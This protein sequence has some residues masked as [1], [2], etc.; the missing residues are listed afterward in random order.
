MPDE[1]TV[2][3]PENVYHWAGPP[4]L[5]LL[6]YQVRNP[7]GGTYPTHA[8]RA[9]NG[10]TGVVIIAL[11][12]TRL[13]VVDQ[14]RPTVGSVLTELPRG[15]G[16]ESSRDAAGWIRDAERELYEETGLRSVDSRLLGTYAPDSSLLPD[17]VAVVR[18]RV[19]NIAADQTDGEVL[20]SRWIERS[21][22]PELVRTGALRDGHTLSALALAS[23]SQHLD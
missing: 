19:E 12:G 16:E 5:D 17:P 13:L 22:I 11:R 18:C 15:F 10:R 4:T 2:G 3:E 20:R 7:S 6:R 23:A 21:T 14:F 1:H 9:Q 8:L